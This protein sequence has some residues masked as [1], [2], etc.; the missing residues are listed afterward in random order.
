MSNLNDA[1]MVSVVMPVFNA[2]KYIETAITSVLKNSYKLLE[3]IIIN[4]CSTDNSMEIINRIKATDNRVFC[5]ENKVQLGAAGSRNLEIKN[6]NGRFLAFCDADDVWSHSKLE[7][8]ISSMLRQGAVISHTSYSVINEHGMHIGTRR[9]LGEGYTSYREMLFRNRIGFST[10][11]IDRIAFESLVMPNCRHEDYAFLLNLM[12]G[13]IQ[14]L[15]IPINTGSYRIHSKNLSK[16]K[17]KSVIWHF[18]VLGGQEKQPF[19]LAFT[20]TLFGRL[21]LIFSRTF[22]PL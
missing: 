6:A 21:R 22:D 8:Q 20:F 11:V 5:L 14:A 3:L 2:E 4:D 13:G 7:C 1:Q 19:F 18:N 16:S 9:L 10:C 12:R 17:L 15:T